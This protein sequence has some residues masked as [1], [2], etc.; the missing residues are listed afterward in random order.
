MSYYNIKNNNLKINSKKS[1]DKLIY[2]WYNII[3][4]K[5]KSK[6][7]YKMYTVEDLRREYSEAA[8]IVR[9]CNL[10]VKSVGEI[11]LGLSPKATRHMGITEKRLDDYTIILNQPYASVAK[12]ED[13]MNT[14]IHEI[15]HTLPGCMNHGENWKYAASIVRKKTGIEIE[16]T[17]YNAEYQKYREENHIYK[18]AVVCEKCGKKSFFQRMSDVVKYPQLY[19]CMCGGNLHLI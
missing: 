2:M 13:R 16:R 4:I 8:E 7:E 9:K 14:I 6:G 11:T 18:Y 10:P 1:I 5:K 19:K 3:A 15:L 12:K 17:G